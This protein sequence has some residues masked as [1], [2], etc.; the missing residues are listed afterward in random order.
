MKRTATFILICMPLAALL[1]TGLLLS[2]VECSAGWLNDRCQKWFEDIYRGGG[3]AMSA[4]IR[5]RAPIER[6]TKMYA[7]IRLRKPCTAFDFA[8]RFEVSHKTIMRDLEFMRDRLGLP[9][10]Y[11]PENRTWTTNKTVRLPWWL[12]INNAVTL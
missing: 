8:Q 10:V 11:D 3:E 2:A 7:L 5:S 1:M 12:E 6:M 9:L 4:M